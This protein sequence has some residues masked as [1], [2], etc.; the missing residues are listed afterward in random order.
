MELVISIVIGF[1]IVEIYAWLPHVSN[2]FI[3][4]AV[5]RLRK[6]DQDRCREEWT[7]NLA[8]LPNTL[9]TLVH[10]IS[11]Y[12]VGAHRSNTEFFETKLTEIDALIEEFGKKHTSAAGNY[13]AAKENLQKRPTR[14]REKLDQ[15]L[16]GIKSL[17]INVPNEKAVSSFHKCVKAIEEFADTYVSV[18]RRAT[19]LLCA[20]VNSATERLD[21]VQGLIL[22]ASEKRNKAAELLT[23]RRVSPHKL[24]SLLADS[25]NDLNI[26]K[27]IFEDG[28]WGDDD[29]LKEHKRIMNILSGLVD[30]MRLQH[31]QNTSQKNGQ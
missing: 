13:R 20:C 17:P 10:A 16:K 11:L 18:N 22:R 30:S 4:R 7:A 9:A 28:K 1:V 3:N 23:Q 14:L 26:V 31:A 29:A 27:S 8:T 21:Q 15:Q 19:D 12:A 2:W 25:I 5:Q 24:E 6:E